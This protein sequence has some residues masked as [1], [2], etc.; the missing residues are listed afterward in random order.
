VTLSATLIAHDEA[1]RV[2]R[3]LESLRWA[4]EIVVV[5]DARTTDATAE[6]ARRFTDRVLVHEFVDYADQ[7]QWAADQ[8][9]GE[10]IFWVDCD[11]VVPEPLA[12]EIQ[13]T[14]RAPRC[15][16]YLLPRRD[17][18]FGKW[19]NHGG[20]YPQLQMRL[21]RRSLGRWRGA[22]HETIEFSGSVGRLAECVLHYSH[23]RVRDW[24]AKMERY[25][26]MEAQALHDAGRRASWATILLE[27]VLYFG[28]KYLVQQGWRD[29]LHGLALASLLGCYRMIRNLKL[30]DLQQATSGP[31]EPEDR[32][33]SATRSSS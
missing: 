14:L 29:G 11:E 7:R 21:Y 4:D 3:C 15:D 6:I 1:E 19:I 25:T 32:P 31:R 2:G 18:M 33:P 13:T 20:W 22:V 17:Y 27:P 9:R 8:A 30:W 12:R 16:A 10:W 5:V 24:V 23:R 28:Y 26:T